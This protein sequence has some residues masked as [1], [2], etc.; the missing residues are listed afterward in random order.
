MSFKNRMKQFGLLTALFMLSL[1]IHILVKEL[2]GKLSAVR[3]VNPQAIEMMNMMRHGDLLVIANNNMMSSVFRKLDGCDISTYKVVVKY[4]GIT[5]LIIADIDDFSD[6]EGTYIN[7]L[8]SFLEDYDHVRLKLYR[9]K[10][11][12]EK[13]LS[14]IN[15]LIKRVEDGLPYDLGFDSSDKSAISCIELVQEAYG[16]DA[17][18]TRNY[19]RF[20]YYSPFMCD[21]RLEEKFNLI[22]DWTDFWSDDIRKQP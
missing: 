6:D 17:M 3:Q 10:I 21:V 9:P 13:I 5:Q 4:R 8:A 20:P 1:M 15:S 18:Y 12:G 14:N 22:M 11:L 19:D 7:P 2:Q 16:I